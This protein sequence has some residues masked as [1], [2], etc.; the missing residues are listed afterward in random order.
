MKAVSL[1][2]NMS[3]FLT[4]WRLSPGHQDAGDRG[5]FIRSVLVAS[6]VLQSTSRADID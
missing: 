6:T 2:A 4:I 1:F 3:R 5:F